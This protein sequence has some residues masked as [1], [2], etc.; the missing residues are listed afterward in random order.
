MSVIYNYRAHRASY[1]TVASPYRASSSPDG[2]SVKSSWR[3]ESNLQLNFT[4]GL[5]NNTSFLRPL[6]GWS[7]W[8]VPERLND[9]ELKHSKA[10]GLWIPFLGTIHV[11]LIQNLRTSTTALIY[12]SWKMYTH[13]HTSLYEQIIVW[14]FIYVPIYK[15]LKCE[16]SFLLR[17]SPGIQVRCLVTG[18]WSYQ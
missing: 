16:P 1:N 14:F 12:S 8:A 3:A 13:S 5:T 17:L 4:Q 2:T 15:T 10:E 18:I 7:H 6:W 11:L 9:S